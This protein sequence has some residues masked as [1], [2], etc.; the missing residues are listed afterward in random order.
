MNRSWN[1]AVLWRR[2]FASAPQILT[3][4][5]AGNL[6]ALTLALIAQYA[7]AMLPCA[8]CIVQRIDVILLLGVSLTGALLARV[9]PRAAP[10]LAALLVAIL[11][12]GGLWA[13]WHQHT[14]AAKQ[15]SCAFTWA[16]RMLMQLALD[17]RWP[18]LFQVQATCA[19]AAHSKMLGLPFE[20]WSAGWFAIVLAMSIFTVVLA[21]Q[22]RSKL[23][24]R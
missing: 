17:T 24:E 6:A 22:P 2:T 11:A 9:A 12:V 1:L 15:L 14:V 3:V 20:L 19:D 13:A 8:W 4:I 16:D 7:W 18:A 10:G 23:L 5:A 21:L